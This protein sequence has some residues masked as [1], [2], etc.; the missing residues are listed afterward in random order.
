MNE[1]SPDVIS[2]DVQQL[3]TF[4]FHRGVSLLF[5]CWFVSCD[6]DLVKIQYIFLLNK[7]THINIRF[8]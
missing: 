4:N 8:I 1:T 3:L 2:T 5:S 7:Y 6:S